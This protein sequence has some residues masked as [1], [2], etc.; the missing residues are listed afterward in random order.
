M[1][2]MRQFET[3][4]FMKDVRIKCDHCNIQFKT[5]ETFGTHLKY[6]HKIVEE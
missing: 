1:I 2:K 5:D 3:R 6:I 4:E